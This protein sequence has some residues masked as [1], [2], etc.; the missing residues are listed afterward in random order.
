M[1]GRVTRRGPIGGACR[2]SVGAAAAALGAPALGH[3]GLAVALVGLAASRRILDRRRALGPKRT[4]RRYIAGRARAAASGRGE[5]GQAER[6][7]EQASV[8]EAEDV[9]HDEDLDL[10][11]EQASRQPAKKRLRDRHI[12]VKSAS[13]PI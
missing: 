6:D 7:R 5:T 4:G 10:L 12:G 1:G 11:Q 13:P 3:V 8:G 9:V 2:P